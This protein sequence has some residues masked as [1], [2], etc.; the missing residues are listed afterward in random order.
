MNEQDKMDILERNREGERKDGT[1]KEGKEKRH[2]RG[3]KGVKGG[4]KRISIKTKVKIV[5]CK[6]QT[7]RLRSLLPIYCKPVFP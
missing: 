5:R 4:G 6:S 7:P 1:R 2:I 3:E